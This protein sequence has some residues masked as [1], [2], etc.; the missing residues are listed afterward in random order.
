[1]LPIEVWV[2]YTKQTTDRLKTRMEPQEQ[3]SAAKND[4][5]DMSVEDYD[6]SAVM[7]ATNPSPLNPTFPLRQPEEDLD[8]SPQLK[9][10]PPTK[11]PCISA[12]GR[13]ASSS[14]STLTAT[15]AS[16]LSTKRSTNAT[17]SEVYDKFYT[18]LPN[19]TL[20]S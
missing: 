6:P 13:T 3:L 17:E 5:F 7:Q 8:D 12:T 1:M 18:N 4:S 15:S 14:A 20:S 2:S 11:V 19:L 9:T 10:P 16:S